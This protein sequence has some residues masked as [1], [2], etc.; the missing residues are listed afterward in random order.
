MFISIGIGGIDIFGASRHNRHW[1]EG[2][3][4][5]TDDPKDQDLK[6]ILLTSALRAM[7][8]EH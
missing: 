6:R 3:T 8:K 2:E 1:R 7:V 4:L 5:T